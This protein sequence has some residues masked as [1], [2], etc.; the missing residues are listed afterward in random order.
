MIIN[1]YICCVIIIKLYSKFTINIVKIEFF[2]ISRDIIIKYFIE[3]VDFDIINDI[4][5]L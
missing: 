1:L 5:C 2:I 4:F 3:F